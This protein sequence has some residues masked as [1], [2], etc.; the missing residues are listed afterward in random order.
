MRIGHSEDIHP[1]EKGRKLYIGGIEIKSEK[2]SVGHSDGDAL[3]HTI[4]EAIFG[5]LALGD[6]GKYF[7][8]QDEKYKNM[9]SKII[10]EK[11]KSLMEE[12][13][14]YIVNVDS[15][16][17]LETPKLAKY[18]D[19]I[20]KNIAGILSTDVNNISV[21]ATTYEGFGAI[22]ENKAWKASTVLLIDK[23]ER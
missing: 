3:L 15:M 14:Y 19:S 17:Y 6:L 9:S 22:G 18:I 8:D 11:A 13:G 10:L 23:D 20:R 5:A 1:L 21:K 12:K 16:V 2:G 7:S 4:A